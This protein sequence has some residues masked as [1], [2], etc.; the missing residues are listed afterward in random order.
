VFLAALSFNPRRTEIPLV[1][2]VEDHRDTRQMYAEF[3]STQFEIAE[4]SD[5]ERALS[6]IH[7]RPPQLVI[8]DLSLPGMNGF[9]MI[10]RLKSDPKTRDI[11]VICLSGFGGHAHEERARELGCNLV[12]QKPC[13]PDELA[14]AAANVIRER[15]RQR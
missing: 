15:E 2:L 12:L 6:M 10:E 9:E 5:A 3:L 11:P 4:A 14:D 8:T 1:L 13:L 7:G